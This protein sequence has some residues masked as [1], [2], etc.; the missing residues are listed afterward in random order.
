MFW[1]ADKNTVFV[2]WRLRLRPLNILGDPG[3]DSGGK[4]K[5]K[6]AE[7][8]GTKKSKE[9]REE[10]GSSR[11]SLLF[12]VPYFSARLDFLLPPLSAP[13]SPRMA[14]KILILCSYKLRISIQRY[15]RILD[16][17]GR[18]GKKAKTRPLLKSNVDNIDEGESP[19]ICFTSK[20]Q[21]PNQTCGNWS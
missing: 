10:R 4:R 17:L 7:K 12:F 6:Q 2:T 15:I 19:F 3:A 20:L 13:G 11:R 9:R 8:Y 14:I 21:T 16:L 18:Y 1:N 5:S